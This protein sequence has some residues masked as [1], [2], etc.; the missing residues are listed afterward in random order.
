MA[1]YQSALHKLLHR[2]IDLDPDDICALR[3]RDPWL[4]KAAVGMWEAAWRWKA[5][6]DKYPEPEAK[7]RLPVVHVKPRLPVVHVG[8]RR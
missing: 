1:T 5:Y 4:A 8:K 2:P 3:A 6:R 7:P